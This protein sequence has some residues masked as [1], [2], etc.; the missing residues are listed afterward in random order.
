MDLRADLEDL[1]KRKFLTLPGLNS[2]PSVIQPVASHYT[3]YA[4]PAHNNVIEH[5]NTRDKKQNILIKYI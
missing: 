3:D 4:I 2:D 1:E 5:K